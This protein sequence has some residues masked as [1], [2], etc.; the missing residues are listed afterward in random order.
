MTMNPYDLCVVFGDDEM[1][2][3]QVWANNEGEAYHAVMMFYKD[4]TVIGVV[5]GSDDKET[6]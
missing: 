1:C 2:C 6:H 4:S 5:F 3:H